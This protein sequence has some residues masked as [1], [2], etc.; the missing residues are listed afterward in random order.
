MSVFA[1]A[2][3]LSAE[4][5]TVLETWSRSRVLPRRQVLRADIVLLASEGIPNETIVKR[6]GTSKPTVLLWRRRFQEE[7]L[8]GLEEAEGR[9]RPAI[10]DQAVAERVVALTM[11]PPPS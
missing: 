9:G 2:I 4:Q 6:L 5:R 11:S 8:E 3:Q 10:Y 1:E 7:G